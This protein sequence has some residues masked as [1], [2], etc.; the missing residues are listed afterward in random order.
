MREREH[1]DER[2]HARAQL[3]SRRDRDEAQKRDLNTQVPAPRVTEHRAKE[4]GLD[5]V[6]VEHP[7]PAVA[8]HPRLDIQPERRRDQCGERC[9]AEAA[10]QP[11]VELPPQIRRAGTDDRQ[12]EGECRRAEQHHRGSKLYQPRGD[13]RGLH[14]PRHGLTVKVKSPSVGCVSTEMTRHLTV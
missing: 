7:V 5:R 3:P 6:G 14:R 2:S 12:G 13:E 9:D 10:P 4:H 1:R 11:A 8:H